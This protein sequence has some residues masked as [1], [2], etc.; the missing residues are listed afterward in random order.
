[1]LKIWLE[2]VDYV[3]NFL[4]SSS[5]DYREVISR[6]KRARYQSAKDALLATV[7]PLESHETTPTSSYVHVIKEDNDEDIT[8]QSKQPKP[9]PPKSSSHFDESGDTLL[10]ALHVVPTNVQ[11]QEA[12]EVEYRLEEVTMKYTKRPKRF[13]YGLYYWFISHFE[14]VPFFFVVIAVASTGAFTSF[15]YAGLLFLWG[16][17]SIPWPTKQ[18]WQSLM[19][20]TMLVLIIKYVYQFFLLSVLDEEAQLFSFTLGVVNLET[21]L[22]WVV[23]IQSESNY[24][25]NA[26]ANLLLLMTLVFHR[27][28][29]KVINIHC[30]LLNHN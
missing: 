2:I 22:A 7:P 28:L 10:N 5:A 27:G 21:I 18:F 30:Y 14:Y 15:I 26:I 13:L 17:L 12:E 8:D 1:M 16:L 29:L 9:E 11:E 23:G 25:R 4:E 6:L 20:Y 24:F 3:I 19:F